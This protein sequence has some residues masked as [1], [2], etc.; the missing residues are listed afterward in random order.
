MSGIVG[1][2]RRQ[3]LSCHGSNK[4]SK[5]DVKAEKCTIKRNKNSDIPQKLAVIILNI[6]TPKKFVVITLKFKL[7]GTTI[8]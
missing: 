7:Y 4:T 3:V 1:N 6:R 2:S 8:E 5:K